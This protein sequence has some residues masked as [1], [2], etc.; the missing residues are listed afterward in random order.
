MHFDPLKIEEKGSDEWWMDRL[1]SRLGARYPRLLLLEQWNDGDPPIPVT[2]NDENEGM[3][4]VRRMT[5]INLA[6]QIVSN[7]RN[8]MIADGFRTAAPGD[9]N[10][11][12]EA[13]R[14]WK[15][16]DMKE[17]SKTIFDDMLVF[18]E[19]YS[20]VAGDKKGD[21]TEALISA[22][23]PRQVITEQHSL[24]RSKTIAALKIYRSD[25]FDADYAVLYLLD[26]DGRPYSRV[27]SREGETKLPGPDATEWNVDAEWEW[28]DPQILKVSEIPVQRFVTGKGKGIFEQHIGSLQTINE[29]RFQRVYIGLGQAAKQQMLI[30]PPDPE[31]QKTGITQFDIEHSDVPLETSPFAVKEPEDESLFGALR[32]GP[33]TRWELPN[34]TKYAESSSTDI[35]PIDEAI[36][37]D[38]RILGEVTGTQFSLAVSEAVNMSASGANAIK[39]R[40]NQIAREERDRNEM[41]LASTIAH[42]FEIEGD[43]TRADKSQIEVIWASIDDSSIKEKSEAAKAAKEA[44]MPWRTR[45]E[46]VFQMTPDQIRA[47][48]QE[49]F[50]EAFNTVTQETEVTTNGNDDESRS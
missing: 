12:A 6:P 22:E 4:T 5:R 21:K 44:G 48:E 28:D 30:R 27:L 32:S 39:A 42:A 11:D 2:T 49:R 10:G 17:V 50:N 46:I 15:R 40:G 37:N 29:D 23:H 19:S 45:M 25:L 36:K 9:E 8:K 3:R 34:G 47:A 14:I 1:A 41:S 26:E 35:R 13:A 18:G 7:I 33:G 20:I 24:Y 38:I 31:P 16:N 43:T